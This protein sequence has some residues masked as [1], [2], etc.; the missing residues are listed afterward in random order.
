[1]AQPLAEHVATEIRAEM[2][3]QR[4][5]QSELAEYLG[6]H[7]VTISKRL[8]GSQ[9]WPLADIERVAQFLNVDSSRFLARVA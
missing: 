7:Q 2:A 1:M 9:P 6:L 8:N 3:R 4:R 5:R